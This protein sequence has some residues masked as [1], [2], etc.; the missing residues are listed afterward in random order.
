MNIREIAKLANVSIATVSR[1]VNRPE[2]VLPETREHVLE[3]MREHSYTLPPARSGKGGRTGN[4]LLL[5]PD[6]GNML[7]QRLM[8]G[9]ESV[10]GPK[11]YVITLCNTHGDAA[12]LQRLLQFGIDHPSVNDEPNANTSQHN[13]L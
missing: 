1:V 7:E 13:S 3:I 10:A 8:A 6:G 5:A 2:V 11:G 9:L 12:E 4:I